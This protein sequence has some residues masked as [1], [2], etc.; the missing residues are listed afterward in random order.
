VLA[1]VVAVALTLQAAGGAACA[2]PP[3]GNVV[4]EGKAT[5]YTP[6]GAAGN[7]S[8]VGFPAD[9]LYVALSPGEYADAAACGGYLD[10]TGP[11]GKVRV[12]V[13]DRCPECPTGHLDLSRKAFARI[14][15]PVRGVVRVTY[16]VVVNPRL[17]GP[18]SFRIKEGA[19]RYW[20]AVLVDNHGNA[21]RGVEVRPKGGS[22]QRVTRTDYNYWLR[23]GGLGPGPYALRLTDVRGQRVTVTGIGLSPRET[24][25]TDVF[26]YGR[27]AAPAVDE[28]KRAGPTR[29]TPAATPTAAPPTTPPSPTLAPDRALPSARPAC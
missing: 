13:V 5:F 14:A 1:A 21:L 12:K 25:R 23:D 15:D 16:R 6:A 3:A 4:H 27:A 29:A 28:P 19:S 2:A 22:W 8:Y 10:V 11:R 18:L 17:P 7:C 20:F 24:Q 9:D 26:M